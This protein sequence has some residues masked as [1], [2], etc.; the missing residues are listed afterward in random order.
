MKKK[1]SGRDRR[2]ERERLGE[3]QCGKRW[4]HISQKGYLKNV[5]PPKMLKLL[6]I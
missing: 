4:G 6:K 2:G 1:R 3:E 5:Y